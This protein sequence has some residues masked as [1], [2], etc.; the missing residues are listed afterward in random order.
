MTL[1]PL[2]LHEPR[3]QIRAAL[4]AIGV[5]ALLSAVMAVVSK[6]FIEG[7][8]CTHYLYARFAIDEPH[9][10]TNVWGRPFCTGIYA[11]PALIAGRIGVRWASMLISVAIAGILWRV[12]RLQG[13]RWPA[14]AVIFTLAQP[15]LF[16]HSFS[17]LTELPF[18]LLLALALAAYQARRWY[19][20]ALVVAIMPTARPEGF[21]FIILTGIALAAHRRWLA[22][23]LLVIALAIWSFAGWWQFGRVQPWYTNGLLW[24]AHQWPY[25]A[26][27]VYDRKNFFFFAA[28][29]PGIVGPFVFPALPLGIWRSLRRRDQKSGEAVDRLNT[30]DCHAKR[31][32]E[33]SGL[34]VRGQIPRE[35]ARDDGFMPSDA[36]LESDPTRQRENRYADHRQRVQ[37]IIAIVPLLVMFGHSYLTWRGK[38]GS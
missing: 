7:D 8:A 9:Y 19:W 22:M 6:G 30:N 38:M 14:L 11:V 5:F 18:A 26:E 17:E 2:P 33:A 27:S 32:R 16:V 20:L 31:T 34:A 37:R 35:Y 4:V 23:P 24:L 1:A 10:L 15:M 3:R 28:M 25:A 21:G 13:Y 36:P 29:L 12:A